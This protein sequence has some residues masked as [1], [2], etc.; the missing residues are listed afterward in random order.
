[1]EGR[2]FSQ[3][4]PPMLSDEELNNYLRQYKNG[5]KDARKKI[6]E[7]HIGFTLYIV[8]H[9]FQNQPY[10]LKDLVS[11]GLLGLIKAVDSFDLDKGYKFTTYSS[12]CIKNEVLMYI[13]KNIKTPKNVSYDNNLANE[14]NDKNTFLDLLPDKTINIEEDYAEKEEK[15]EIARVINSLKPDEQKLIK[16][17]FGFGCKQ[18]NQYELSQVFN[19]S[20]SY[21]S[22]KIRKVLA[23]IKIEL[24]NNEVKQL[25]K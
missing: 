4:T 13:R 15:E 2:N 19:V 11:I 24:L 6:I 5:N 16:L 9:Y 22:R 7:H 23:K 21:L 14:S 20:Q 25:Q 8:T 1:M 17:Y 10:D 3:E 18:L 12:R